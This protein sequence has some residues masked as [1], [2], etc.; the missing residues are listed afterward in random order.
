[1][2]RRCL[3]WLALAVLA[4]A[5]WEWMPLTALLTP[6]P[7]RTAAIYAAIAR[8]GG[9]GR[10]AGFVC[11]AEPAAP[12]HRR[13]CRMVCGGLPPPPSALLDAAR[14]YYR[15]DAL[16]A[17]AGSQAAIHTLPPAPR[18]PGDAGDADVRRTPLGLASRWPG[19]ATAA[20]GRGAAA[21]R[22]PQR[23]AG[24]VP[25]NNPGGE[26]VDPEVLLACARRLAERG[27]WLLVD[28]TFI[29]ATPRPA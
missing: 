24:A 7:R 14:G 1:M 19:Y 23:G 20:S 28:E 9:V 12:T 16:L 11:R 15:A 8:F 2:R 25:A 26:C 27:G 21:R 10:L 29:D 18:Q 6:P 3:L 22:R 13:R 5:G 4:A 17:S